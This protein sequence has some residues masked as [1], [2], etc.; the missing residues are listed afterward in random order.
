MSENSE[1]D[2]TTKQDEEYSTVYTLKLREHEASTVRWVGGR[3]CWSDALLSYLDYAESDEGVELTQEDLD[4]LKSQ[5]D[6]DTVGGHDYFP[7]LNPGS[8]LYRKLSELYCSGEEP[9]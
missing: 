4:Y 1:L 5:F 3:Y 2:T 7:C 9:V 8:S 6:E